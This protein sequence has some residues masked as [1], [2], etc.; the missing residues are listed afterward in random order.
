MK[1]RTKVS[2][3]FLTF[4]IIS[5]SFSGLIWPLITE[6]Q[7]TS[8]FGEYRVGHIHAGIDLRTP[9]GDGM[10]II[11]LADGSV[12]RAREGPWGYGKAIYYQM[13]D[14]YTAVFAHL[15]GFADTLAERMDFE[16]RRLKKSSVELWFKG[17]EFP[18]KAGDTIAFSGSTGAGSAHLHFEIRRGYDN[19]INP[20]LRGY[21]TDDKKSPRIDAVY[22]IPKS[23]RAH[24]QGKFSPIKFAVSQDGKINKGEPIIA[25]GDIAIAIDCFDLESEKNANR[26]GVYKIELLADGMQTYFF[27]ADSFLFSK[28]RQIGLI[29]DLSIQSEL[30]LNRP[31]FYLGKS[32]FVDL[33]LLSDT[34][35][36]SGIF[37]INKD[38]MNFTIRVADYLGNKHEVSFSIVNSPFPILPEVN[39]IKRERRAVVS[40]EMEPEDTI[41]LRLEYFI[42]LAKDKPYSG[43]LPIRDFP[44]E[45]PSDVI[46]AR[47]IGSGFKNPLWFWRDG[48]DSIPHISS[49]I[50]GYNLMFVIAEFPGALTGAPILIRSGN[51]I[52]CE[53]IDDKKCVF[54]IFDPIPSEEYKLIWNSDS[55][56]I[57]AKITQ[58]DEGSSIPFS[59][60]QWSL[61]FPKGSLFS[62][63]LMRDTLLSGSCIRIEPEG[64]LLRSFAR[65]SFD[66]TGSGAIP[67]KSCIV[68]IWNDRKIF[69][70]NEL[71]KKGNIIAQINTFGDFGIEPDTIPPTLKLGIKKGAIVLK[72][73]SASLWDDLSNFSADNLPDNYI[74]GEW[75]P[76]EYDPDKRSFTV[77]I[78]KLAPGTHKWVVRAKDLAGNAVADSVEFIK[79]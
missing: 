64:V 73:L 14:G 2:I 59:G 23:D 31:P 3:L 40:S 34:P 47:I 78:D 20:A 54:R 8:S 77:A 67:K 49:R 5:T 36:N 65:L 70:S 62:P 79:K 60:G 9:D 28:T 16:K 17:D 75:F 11:A 43:R 68:R 4:G 33:E 71:D 61:H 72:N 37:T 7:L 29:Y 76:M 1:I 27:R 30:E 39:L 22:L 21:F 57:T 12:I 63:I 53:I 45:L 41:G 10:P 19:A 52:P 55:I 25:S 48:V 69:V 35:E 56:I 66:T 46:Y 42:P 18:F 13:A 24:I 26:Y 15:S 6:Y 51:R 50:L 38:T 32:P 58:A 44:T 74:D